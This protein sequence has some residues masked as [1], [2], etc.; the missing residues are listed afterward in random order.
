MPTKTLEFLKK[1][2][3]SRSFAENV[4]LTPANLSGDV[5]WGVSCDFQQDFE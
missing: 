1:P 2:Y 3:L 4:T 5:E